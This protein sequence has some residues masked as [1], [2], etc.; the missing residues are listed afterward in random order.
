[1]GSCPSG[2]L[3]WWEVALVGCSPCCPIVGN[4]PSG[5]SSCCQGVV[6]PWELS[7][8]KLTSGELS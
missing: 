5:E 1:M 7:G 8:G 4:R 2:E 3:S 6:P